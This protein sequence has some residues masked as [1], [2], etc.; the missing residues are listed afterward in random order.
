MSNLSLREKKNTLSHV[1]Y[2]FYLIS[3]K[4]SHEKCYVHFQKLY[5]KCI[6][7]GKKYQIAKK[8]STSVTS[9]LLSC[10]AMSCELI[11]LW[12]HIL[13]SVSKILPQHTSSAFGS[14]NERCLEY[15]SGPG[16][17]YKAVWVPDHR[18]YHSGSRLHSSLDP[19][20]CVF[21]ICDNLK[22]NRN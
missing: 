12:N 3:I 8:Y 7:K 18:E 21:D 1:M 17:G 19:L 4:Q 20:P 5:V 6:C 22:V 2:D 10:H 15:S 16:T 9:F 14:L 13:L 11:N